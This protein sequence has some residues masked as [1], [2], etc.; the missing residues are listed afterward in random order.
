[1]SKKNSTIVK[2]GDNSW[3]TIKEKK[4]LVTHTI[5]TSDETYFT[6]R[7]QCSPDDTFDV[8]KGKRIAKLRAIIALKK[9][10]LS[11]LRADKEFISRVILTNSLREKFIREIADEIQVYMTSIKNLEKKVLERS[12]EHV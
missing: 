9:D 3:Y 4:R 7:S 6:G 8:E 5:L 10:Q 2:A 11:S 1:M 12:E